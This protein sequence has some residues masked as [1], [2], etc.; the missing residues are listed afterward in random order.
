[1]R[2]L[3]LLLLGML[4]LPAAAGPQQAP[5][6]RTREVL[7][8]LRPH[9]ML[10]VAAG[11]GDRW[12]EETRAQGCRWDMR[13]QYLAGGVTSGNKW[14]LG[15]FVQNYIQES[16]RQGT[17]PVFTWYQLLQ[18][19]G[20]GDEKQRDRA[21][22]QNVD[23]M[24]AYFTDIRAFMKE[25]GATGKTAI[26]HVEPDMWGYFLVYPDADADK[27]PVQVKATG[28]PELAKLDDTL[29][30]FGKAITA[31]RD[32]LAP[33]IL[34]AFHVSKWGD[35]NPK[36]YAD[37]IQKCGKWDLVFTDPSDRDSAWKIAKNYQAGGAWWKD[38][39]FASFRDWSRKIHDLTGLPLMAWQ[40]PMGNTVMDSC[41]NTEGHFMDNRPEYFLDNYP[42]NRHIAEWAACGYVGLLFG[43]GA[44]GCTSVRDTLK[45]GVTNPAPVQGNKGEKA[46]FPDDDGGFMRVRGGNYYTKGPV[47]LLRR[48]ESPSP[49]EFA[50]G[51]EA[52]VKGEYGRAWRHFSKVVEVNDTAELVTAAKDRVR[53]I[54]EAVRKRYAEVRALEAIGETADAIAAYRQVVKEYAGMPAAEE[55][56]RKADSLQR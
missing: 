37:A 2:H 24:R 14:Y 54:E 25:A 18:S 33:N 49:R 21:N 41:N 1:M 46:A 45:D 7:A 42:V 44:G 5:S 10:G 40:I 4:A 27:V 26:F 38:Q 48:G 56:R 17:V 22:A 36:T 3:P 8:K 31:Y 34:L 13:Y 19:G 30:G 28:L 51:S 39:D 50:Q 55:A 11:P 23:I 52:L 35:P 12:I 32:Q 29:A 6:P 9:F 47:P 16:E 53:R 15:G 43:G 20:G